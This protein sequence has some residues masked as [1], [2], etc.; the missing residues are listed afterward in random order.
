MSDTPT[1]RNLTNGEYGR[2]K[3]YQNKLLEDAVRPHIESF[4]YMLDDGLAQAVRN[5]NPVEFLLD[6][7]RI[8]LS[9]EDAFIGVPTIARGNLFASTLKVYP[10]ECRQRGTTYQAPLQARVL[11]QRSNGDSGSVMRPL[12]QIPIL[13]KCKNCNLHN[14]PPSE[15]VKR[16]EEG[17]EMGGYFIANGIEK[18]IRMLVMP[19]R[20]FPLAINRPKWK[21]RGKGFTEF[22][23]QMRCVRNDQS[24]VTITL[25]YLTTGSIVVSF[26]YNKEIFFLP[27]LLVVR[28]L[29][30]ISDQHIYDELVKGKENDTFLVGCVTGMLRQTHTQNLSSQEQALE[31]IGERFRIKLSAPPWY[32]NAQTAKFL[33]QQCICVHLDSN[34]DKFHTLTFMARKLFAFTQGECAAE[35]ADSPMN[36]EVLLAGHLYLMVLKE[37]LEGW[38]VNLRYAIEKQAKKSRRFVLNDVSLNN[39]ASS[40]PGDLTRKMEYLIATGNLASKTGLGLMQTSGMTVVAD[41]LNFMRFLSHFRCIHRGSF[42]AEMR[43]TSVRKLLPEAWGFLCPVHTPDG[44][45]CGLMN[46]LTALCQVVNTQPLTLPLVKTLYALGMTPLD[47]PLSHPVSSCYEVILDGRVLGY[48]PQDIATQLTSRLKILKVKGQSGVCQ[49][50]EIVLVPVSGKG[51]QYPGLYIFT[52]PS[53]LY[54]PVRNLALQETEYIGTFE[55]VYMDIAVSPAEIHQKTTHLEVNE[56]SIL[57]VS[58]SLTPFSDF[59]QSPRNMYQ[60]QMGKQTMGFPSHTLP[61]RIDHKMYKL[62]TPQTPMV[63][64]HSYDKYDFD[65]YPLGTNAVVAVISYTGYDMEDAMIINKS[66]LERGFGHASIYKTEEINLRNKLGESR[67]GRVA[68]VFGCDITDPRIKGCIDKD[69]FPPIGTVLH[70]GDPYYAYTRLDSGQTK[71]EKY[72]GS[73]VAVVDNVKVTGGYLGNQVCQRA[74]IQLR[75]QR[76]PII[77]DKFSSRHG[78]K[79]V[80]SQ[81]WPTEDMPFTES[82]MTPDILFNPHGFPSRMTIGMMIESM[83]GKSASLHGLCHDATPFT[84]SEEQPAVDY[85]GKLLTAGGYNYYGTERMYSGTSGVELE[86]DIFIG[87]VYY[88]R[89]RHMVSDKFQVRSTGPVDILTHQPVK[90]RKRAGGIRFGEMERDSLLAHGTSF[91]L[92]DRLLNCSD[93]SLTRICTKCGTLLGIHLEKLSDRSSDGKMDLQ[94]MLSS[95]Q[96]KWVCASCDTSDSIE[97]ITVPYVFQYLVAELSAMNIKA[98]LEVK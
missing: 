54:R 32:T 92:Q 30:D 39:A 48:V 9:Y 35:N 69:G 84:F 42:F 1:Y 67:H 24:I 61:F 19:R 22:G 5:I 34:Q 80:C 20:N 88:Q 36:Q 8:S 29:V 40:G 16:K 51:G 12:G 27:L 63:R 47:A 75:I 77:G 28:A 78:Q 55:Q 66:S 26:A 56:T 85:F 82:G 3:E 7:E 18:V 15:L 50:T 14:L 71:V 60:C 53:R 38:L 59:N 93:K 52:T 25:H 31:Y 11:W 87:V 17:S 57:S 21:S 79:G 58:A 62:Q 94:D 98:T 97:T 65:D 96:R 64:P 73:E 81:R 89:L 70:E 45:P 72:R 2:P 76:N 86:A 41:K 43:T 6:D 37:K 10:S 83:A 13:V 49:T 95:A 33:L 90:G 44:A 4:N 91:L 46:H 68:A 74:F 23:V